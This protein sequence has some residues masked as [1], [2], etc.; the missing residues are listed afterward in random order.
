[1]DQ[2]NKAHLQSCI[3]NLDSAPVGELVHLLR[4]H[5]QHSKSSQR[6]ALNTRLHYLK[7]LEFPTKYDQQLTRLDEWFDLAVRGQAVDNPIYTGYT[8]IEDLL[9]SMRR[10]NESIFQTHYDRML[11]QEKAEVPSNFKA[12]IDE[13]KQKLSANGSIAP[14]R[15]MIPRSTF[16]TLQGTSHGSADDDEPRII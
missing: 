16:A 13:L 15:T 8:I 12:V 14:P 6:S 11:Q 7:N 5:R 4:T 2:S 3:N 10:F 1:M 9:V